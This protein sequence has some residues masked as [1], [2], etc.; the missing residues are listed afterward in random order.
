[1]QTY[2]LKKHTPVVDRSK[3]IHNIKWEFIAYGQLTHARLNR[4]APSG[5]IA[6]VICNSQQRDALVSCFPDFIVSPLAHFGKL[7]LV[8]IDKHLSL[9]FHSRLEK[10]KSDILLLDNEIPVRLL[11]TAGLY[12]FGEFDCLKFLV[13]TGRGERYLIPNS[14]LSCR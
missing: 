7:S 6:V 13:L 3:G 5:S 14:R 1:M 11:G 10:P 8:T 9:P 2:K 4:M 12:Y